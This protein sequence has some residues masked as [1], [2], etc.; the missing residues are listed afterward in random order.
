MCGTAV[1]PV[2]ERSRA[3]GAM[4]PVLGFG[5]VE[6]GVGGSSGGVGHLRV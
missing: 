3:D 1:P 2:E 4:P 6:G 5:S